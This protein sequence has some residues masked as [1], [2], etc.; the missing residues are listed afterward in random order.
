MT[1]TLGKKGKF[2][3]RG[4]ENEWDQYALSSLFAFIFWGTNWL[5]VFNMPWISTMAPHEQL[6]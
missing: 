2:G 4:E 6:W 5:K 3:L 1:S